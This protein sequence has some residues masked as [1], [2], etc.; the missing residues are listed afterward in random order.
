MSNAERLTLQ[1]LTISFSLVAKNTPLKRPHPSEVVLLIM[2]T[3][4]WH[5]EG[6]PLKDQ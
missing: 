3:G 5:R 1:V 2:V 4:E 6:A